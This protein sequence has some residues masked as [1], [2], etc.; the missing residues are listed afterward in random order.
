[1]LTNLTQDVWFAARTLLRNRGFA[2]SA[3]LILA[4]GIAASTGLFAVI[5]A[6]VLH[7][8][9]YAGADRIAGIRLVTSSGRPRPA[10]VNA[11]EFRALRTASTLDDAYIHG[12]FTK[13]LLGTSFPESVWIEDFSGNALS[14][15]GVQPLLGRVFSEADA[16]IGSE[17]QRVAVLT[18]PFWQRRFAGQPDVIGQALRLDGQPFTIIGVIPRDYTTDATDVVVP[19]QLPPASDEMGPVTVRLKPGVSIA[20]AE[21]ELQ[22]VYE[23]FTR[24]RPAAYPP[25]FRVQLSRLVDQERGAEYVPVLGLVFGAA[26]LLLLIGC[27]NVTILLLARGRYRMREMA[28]RQALGAVRRRL[29]SL[30]LAETLLVTLAAVGVALLAVT[31]ALPLILEEVPGVLAQRAARIVVG[32]TA[33]LFAITVSALVS[34]I[35]GV[36]PALAVSRA[37][38]DAMRTASVVRGGAGAGRASSGFLVGAQ[39]A[40]AVVLLAGTGAAIRALVDLYRAPVGYDPARVTIAQIHLPV[41]SY[42]DWPARVALYQRLRSELTSESVVESASISLIPTGPPPRTGVPARIDAEGLRTDDREVLVHSVASD[43]FSTLKMPLVRGRTWTPADDERAAPVVV[44]NETMARQLWPNED[45][46][47]KQV[48]DRSFLE[49]R[50]Q[51]IL[52]APGRDGSFEVIGVLRDAPNQGLRE[53]IAPAMYYPYTVALSDIAVLLVRTK[54]SPLA[55][56]ARLRAAVSRADGNLPIIRFITPETFMGRQQ[57]E[58]VSAVLLGFAGVALVLASFG[59]FSVACYTIAHRTREFGIRIALGAAPSAVLRSALQST[60]LAVFAGLGAGL[61]V[62]VGLSSLLAHWSIR[63]VDDPVVLIAAV[64]T[65]LLATGIATL[66][67]ARRATAIQ[68]AIALRAE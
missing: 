57:G 52:Q 56:E 54:E 37:R 48:R 47:G 22:S 43:Y 59:L 32:P 27:A 29:V 55:A 46:I 30:L 6:V 28:V 8:L 60:M 11:D 65:L 44:I 41:A 34:M 10:I 36:W 64:G 40:I 18:Y 58:F 68:P 13:T 9:P 4:L 39:V 23:E 49:R 31:Y 7:P 17:P 35:V 21:A 12:S 66:I 1:M 61:V 20:Q 33:I 16:P 38:S 5:D 2:A 50:P 51:W 63:N 45:P 24:A 19:L 53:P 67:P 3:M 25:G 62:S 15:L 26:A 14:M 42:T